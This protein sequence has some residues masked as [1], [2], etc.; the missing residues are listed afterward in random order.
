MRISLAWLGEWVDSGLDASELAA[1]LTMSGLE[2]ESVEPAA[3]DF[4]GVV[5]G[6]VLS[7]ERHRDADKLTVCQVAGGSAGRLQVVCGAPNVRPG[8]KAPLALEGARLAAG[9]IIRRTRLRGVESAGMLCSARELGLSEEHEGILELPD[10]LAPGTALRDALALD[11]TILTLNVTP[12][13]G[14]VL[15]VLGVAR[16]VAAI[17]ARKLMPPALDAVAPATREKFDVR[18][19]APAHCPRFAGRVVQ[20]VDPAVPTPL[21]MRERL[22]RAGLR[23]IRPV[24]DVTNY[25]MLE[26]GQPLHAYDLRRLRGHIEVRMARPGEKLLLLDGREMALEPDTLVIADAAGPVGLAGVMGGEKSGIAADTA[27]ILLEGAFFPPDTVAGVAR[28]NGLVTDAAQRFERGVDPRGQERAIERATELL[29]AIAGGRPGPT[30]VTQDDAHLPRRPGVNLRPERVASLLGVEVPGAEIE[31]ILRRLGMQVA[32]A[33]DMLGVIPPSHRF[34]ISIEQDLIEEVGRIHGYDNIP[35][36]DA[37]MPQRPQPSTERAVTRERLR[38]LLVDRGYQEVITYSFVDP[39]LQRRMFPTR[40]ALALANPLSA[41][42]GEMRT[43]LWPGLVETLRFN[44]RRQQDRVRI[45]EV[46]T[47][48]EISAQR[49]VESQSIAG[50][51]SGAALPE[52]WG[53]EGRAADFYDLKSDVEALF[54]LTG[55]QAAISYV[56]ATHECLHPGR[57]AAIH[58]GKSHVGWLGHLQPELARRL[59]LRDAP[60]MFEIA[61]DPSFRSEV[62]VFREVSRYPAIRRDLAVVIDESVTLDELR[63][64]VNLAA[65]GLLRELAVFDVYRGKG[66]EPGRKSIALG[67]ILQETSRTL[68]DNE[69]DAVVAAVIERVRGDLKAGIRE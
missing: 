13:R 20:G 6:E 15:S 4:Q 27:D 50:L 23:P 42:L 26:L 16:E 67:L 5:V 45:F 35:C 31:E 19:E 3:G 38:L 55:R 29:V 40:E 17:T 9:D 34:D 21:W 22:R 58:D 32:G 2:V 8:M 65:K 10:E 11:D 12:N 7:V 61:I 41:E 57:S 63:E 62:P 60:W 48:F 37:K 68:T 52:Q 54:A 36:S 47:R 49:L 51:V 66:I 24:V 28:R 46:G 39:R 44:L 14:D 1:R 64:S 18:L 25:V 33:G 30:I 59:E 43:S 69:A 56:A 53:I